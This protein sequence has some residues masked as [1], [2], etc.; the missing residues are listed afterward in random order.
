MKVLVVGCGNIGSVAAEDLAK[1]IGSV[2]V[3]VADKNETYAKNV[4]EKIRRKN[5]SW[6]QLD[7]TDRNKLVKTM[8]D[9]SLVMGFL[10]GRFGYGLVETCIDTGKDL[11][12]V[13]YMPE[14]PLTL[15]E[16]AVNADVQIIPDCGLTPGISNILVGHAKA[17][18]DKV[19][20]VHIM[21]GGLPEKP[22]PPLGYV[23]TWSPENLIDEYTRKAT[24]VENGKKVEVKALS[25]LETV[26]F[27][28][29]GRLE[30]FF[31]DGLRTLLHTM[32]D[33]CDM[34]EKTLRYLGHAEKIK[35]LEALGFFEEEPISVDGIGVSPRKFTAKLFTRKLWKPEVKD[36]VALKVE[37]S[38]IQDNKRAVYVYHLLD[39]Y[40][41][42]HGITAMARTTAYPASIIAQ[43]MLMK[44]VKGEGVIP[45]EE[46]GMD[47]KLFRMFLG[48]LGKRGI[49]VNEEVIR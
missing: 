43:F 41:K 40:D 48:E 33:A 32:P 16:K 49:R 24:I 23:I 25:G 35:L 17:K 29:L 37:V 20:T 31:T 2:D 7:T 27:S 6:I 15:H 5:V 14:S 8:K 10:P 9:F 18:L 39:Y 12:D 11:V 36:V 26:D 22:T 38:G 3:V 46:I 45:P 13:S 21:V 47:S 42:E 19:E 34:W 1:S 44:A 28:G 30:A 4:A